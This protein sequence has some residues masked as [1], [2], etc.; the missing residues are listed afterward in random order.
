MATWTRASALIT[1][2]SPLGDDVLIPISLSAQEA[3]S[4]PFQFE[5]AA[6]CQTG[7]VDRDALL[8]QPAC[9]TLQSMG[10]P[11]RYFHGIIRGVNAEGTVRGT[12]GAATQQVYSIVLVPRLW[13]LGQTL[14]CRV[15]QKKSAGDILEAMFQ[16]AGITDVSGP[17]SSS[18]REYT[19]QFNESDL[20]F[21]TRLMEEEG[22]FY[23]FEHAAAKHTLGID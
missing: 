10:T 5:I 22:W 1:M 2:T 11:V 13:F 9:V 19:V 7:V 23:F 17:P 12:T 6:V 18:Q 16:D 8:Y 21:T 4:Q 20:H 3:I 15:Y 14:D